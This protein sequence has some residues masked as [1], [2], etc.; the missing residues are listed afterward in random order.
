MTLAEVNPALAVL[1]GFTISLSAQL[2]LAIFGSFGL[3]A[4][5]LDLSAQFNAALSLNASLSISISNPIASFQA[6]LAA[7]IQVTAN[8]ELAL[9]LG[10]PT[11]GL[12]ISASISASAALS[13][14]LSIKLGGISAL[15]SAALAIKLP[16]LQF[17]GEL[18]LGAGPIDVLTFGFDAPMTAA[19]VG[20]EAAAQF[21]ALPGILPTDEVSGVMIVTKNPTAALALAGIFKVA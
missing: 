20:A 11:I 8:I 10:L 12:S 5:Q 18:N 4:L 9:S 7:L 15:I 19:Q 6:A 3:G 16:A 1:G 17:V 2:D 13:A 21:S 14:S